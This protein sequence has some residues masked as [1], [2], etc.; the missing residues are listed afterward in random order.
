MTRLRPLRVLAMA[1]WAL[2]V[3]FPIGSC[4]PVQQ[5]S[6]RSPSD[7]GAELGVEAKARLQADLEIAQMRWAQCLRHETARLARSG[8]PGA[9][10]CAADEERLRAAWAKLNAGSQPDGPAANS[11]IDG[12]R[13][14]MAPE[15][16]EIHSR[17]NYE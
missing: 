6:L 8:A 4:T 10:S 2:A 12:L 3:T 9:L 1:G 11:F 14:A 7:R 17:N 15:L 5:T 16:R 13:S